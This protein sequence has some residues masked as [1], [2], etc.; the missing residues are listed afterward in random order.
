MS[1]FNSSYSLTLPNGKESVVLGCDGVNYI[2]F[3]DIKGFLKPDDNNGSNKL[4]CSKC[5]KPGVVICVECFGEAML[6]S[7]KVARQL[8]TC[9]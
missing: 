2:K 8:I 1:N 4:P 7:V 6:E 9:R 5:G 3:D